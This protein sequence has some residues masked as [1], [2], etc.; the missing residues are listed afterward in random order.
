VELPAGTYN[1]LA[2][3]FHPNLE[4]TFELIIAGS[5]NIKKAKFYELTPDLDWKKQQVQGEWAPGKDGGCS[6]NKSTWM[7]NPTYCLAVNRKAT[8][9]VVVDV[10]APKSAIGYY[11]FTTK[12]GKQVLNGSSSFVQGSKNVTVAKDWDLEPGKYLLMPATFE[13]K[14]HGSFVLTVYSEH[15]FTLSTV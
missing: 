5:P 11:V 4:N 3:T 9:K 13:P 15:P 10:A 6:N 14:L 2:S 7:Q 1:I 8:L 12:D